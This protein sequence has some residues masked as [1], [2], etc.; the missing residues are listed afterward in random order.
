LGNFGGAGSGLNG[1]LALLGLGQALNTT[2]DSSRLSAK[3]VVRGH[4]GP[5]AYNHIFREVHDGVGRPRESTRGPQALD[6]NRPTLGNQVLRSD[7][8]YRRICHLYV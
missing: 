7:G 5:I 8:R 3:H 2:T 6:R 4:A 1:E